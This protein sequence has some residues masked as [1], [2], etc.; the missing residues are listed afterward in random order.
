[1]TRFAIFTQCSDD[2]IDCH[3]QLCFVMYDFRGPVAWLLVTLNLGLGL[4]SV[5]SVDTLS[6][7]SPIIAFATF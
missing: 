5:S 2:S 4:F 3:L 1:M 6:N 7:A